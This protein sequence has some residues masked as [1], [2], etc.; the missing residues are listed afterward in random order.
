MFFDYCISDHTFFSRRMTQ[1]SHADTLREL[2]PELPQKIHDWK[3]SQE[4]CIGRVTPG[5]DR[6][7]LI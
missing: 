1:N 3:A 4:V 5:W 2:Q 6:D 7:I